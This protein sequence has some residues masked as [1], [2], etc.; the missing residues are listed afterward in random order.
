MRKLFYIPVCLTAIIGLSGCA[1]VGGAK[2]AVVGF[3]AE[4][5]NDYCE[6]RDDSLRD[7][8]IARINTALREEGAKWTLL[9]VQCDA[10]E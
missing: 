9:G 2:D 1:A 8:A 6:V 7:E 3:V 10:A 4:K 5:G